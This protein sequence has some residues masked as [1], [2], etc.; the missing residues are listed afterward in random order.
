M[1]DRVKIREVRILSKRWGELREYVFE[2][3]RRDGTTQV[4][5]RE[6]YDRGDSAAVLILCRSRQTVILTRQ[7]RMPILAGG[8]DGGLVI[9][10]P[11]GLVENRTPEDAVRREVT[12]ETGVSIGS[13]TKV[14]EV[15]PN[16]SVITER[17][18]L[19][20]AECEPEARRFPGG[21][22]ASEGEDIEVL[23]FSTAEVMEMIECG[24]IKDSKTIILFLFATTHG[25]V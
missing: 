5:G 16:P 21:G 22:L 18:H 8:H 23:E 15:F 10:V 24:K 17:V 2:F 3:L 13:L 19:F 12:Q 25:L 14:L 7:I 4:L 1:S 20:I 11:A 9:E 6:V